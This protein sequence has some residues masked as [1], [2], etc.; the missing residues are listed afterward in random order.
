MQFSKWDH[1]VAELFFSRR[2]LPGTVIIGADSHSCSAGCVGA[3]ATGLGAADVLMPV[4][5]GQTWMR[6][7]ETILIELTGDLA[8]GLTGKDLWALIGFT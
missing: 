5:S 3:F 7:P 1:H 4:L 6:V 8:F 2:A